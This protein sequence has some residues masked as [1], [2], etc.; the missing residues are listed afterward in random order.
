MSTTQKHLAI[1]DIVEDIILLKDGGGSLVIKTNAVNFGLLS[2]IE[3]AAII[4]SFAQLLN[5]LS[6]SIQIVI[7]SQQLD[8]SSYI[9]LL[10]IA[11]KSQNNSL[12]A[13]MIAKYR[14]F[15]QSLVKENEVLDKQFYIVLNVSSIELGIGFSDKQD[16]INRIKTILNPR[17]DQILKQLSRIGLKSDQLTTP[18][19]VKLFYD[20]YN[21]TSTQ[22]IPKSVTASNFVQPVRLGNPQPA[23]PQPTPS[24]PPQPQ[25]PTQPAPVN[26]N[27][28]PVWQNPRP[29]NRSHPFV[30]EE[31]VDSV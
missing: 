29:T 16:H 18:E 14:Q 22:E 12:L 9:A 17:R 26:P 31:L 24:A 13:G 3:Q 30:V 4:G 11:Q 27:N 10:D 19:L 1:S 25:H 5:S 7:H 8:V 6:Y 2:E 23:S 21:Q 28:Q 20:L 15:I